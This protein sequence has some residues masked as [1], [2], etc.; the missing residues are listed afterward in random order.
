MVA[1]PKG[2]DLNNLESLWSN[3]GKT[4]KNKKT[5]VY[6]SIQNGTTPYDIENPGLD[7]TFEMFQNKPEE[8]PS[9]IKDFGKRDISNE[10]HTFD[11]LEYK[12]AKQQV[13]NGLLRE[14]MVPNSNGNF[15]K[16]SLNEKGSPYGYIIAHKAPKEQ[17]EFENFYHTLVDNN[18]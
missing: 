1:P 12:Y 14:T 16:S 4:D 6:E 2:F 9:K 10:Y 5:K 8:I 15:I 3:T 17:F 11:E 18:V 7:N 13:N